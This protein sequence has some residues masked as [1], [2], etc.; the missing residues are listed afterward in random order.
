MTEDVLNINSIQQVGR[1]GFFHSKSLLR[2]TMPISFLI[3]LEKT[4]NHVH[5]SCADDLLMSYMS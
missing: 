5:H 3:G 4:A 1:V 2:D